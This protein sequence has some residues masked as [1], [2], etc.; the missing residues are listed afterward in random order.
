MPVTDIIRFFRSKNILKWNE[1][2]I[3]AWFVGLAD[4]LKAG[5]LRLGIKETLKGFSNSLGK[6]GFYLYK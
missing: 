2:L 5:R 6:Q 4:L 3:L 1:L